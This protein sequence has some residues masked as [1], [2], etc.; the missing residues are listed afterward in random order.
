[1]ALFKI[2]KGLSSD[3][4]NSNNSVNSLTHEGYCY[5]TTDDGKFYID[6]VDKETPRTPDDTGSLK[7][8]TRMPINS[9]LSDYAARAYCDIQGKEID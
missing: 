9:Y 5:F 4:N 7:N 6:I 8:V 3:F 2:Y 1:M